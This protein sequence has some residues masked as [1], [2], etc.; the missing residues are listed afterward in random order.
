M[1]RTAIFFCAAFLAGG[2]VNAQE[3]SDDQ[4]QECP[5]GYDYKSE[6]FSCKVN[7]SGS[8][9][10]LKLG[11]K[12]LID[13]GQIFARLKTKEVQK[14]T[15]I[16]QNTKSSSTLKAKQEGEKVIVLCEGPLQSKATG[17]VGDFKEKITFAPGRIVL[18]YEV[19]SSVELEMKHWMPFCSLLSAKVDNFIGW[20]LDATDQKGENGIYEI[21]EEYSKEKE[22][23]SRNLNNAKF[24][25]DS[26]TFEL[27]LDDEKKTVMS[28]SDGRSWKGKGME[29]VIKPIMPR[30]KRGGAI[31]SYPLG[32]VFK[33][34]FALSA[35]K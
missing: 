31:V 33:W 27:K 26:N 4:W 35:Q 2:A 19:K 32:S 25:L 12:K 24:I 21:P 9:C 6:T 18:E 14:E 10:D 5:K 28:V 23:W 3:T 13:L 16:F 7:N 17:K 34:S 8:L 20:A 1:K 15:R 11:D 30:P 22:S 29:I